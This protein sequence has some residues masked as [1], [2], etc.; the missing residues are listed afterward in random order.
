MSDKTFWME[1]TDREVRGLRRYARERDLSNSEEWTCAAGWHT[2]IEWLPGDF[3]CP[4]SEDGMH[5][6]VWEDEEVPHDNPLWPVE[7]DKGCGYRFT[8]EDDWQQW[9]SRLWRRTDSGYYLLLHQNLVHPDYVL[10]GA[11]AM[12]DAKWMGRSGPD[13]ICLTVRCP[14]GDGTPGWLNDWMV[15]SPPSG[16]GTPWSRTGDPRQANVTA[17]PSIAIGIPG[18]PGYYHGFLQNG[19]LTNHLG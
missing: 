15:D 16:G 7:C 2:A 19:L 12:W 11:G 8:E 4:I 13:G 9:S 14:R 10:A 5:R 17:S 1:Q 6:C 3:H 18:T